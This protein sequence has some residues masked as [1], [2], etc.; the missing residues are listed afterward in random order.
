[1]PGNGIWLRL[2]PSAGNLGT[3]AA[4]PV[5]LADG[6]FPTSCSGRLL[7]A[8]WL[9]AGSGTS[10][11]AQAVV[12]PD[13]SEEDHQRLL[14][15]F[16]SVQIPDFDHAILGSF[17]NGDVK[18]STSAAVLAM[19]GTGAPE[20]VLAAH[21]DDFTPG[22]VLELG[23]PQGLSLAGGGSLGGVKIDA[24][25]QIVVDSAILAGQTV[26]VGAV[27][28]DAARVEVRVDGGQTVDA[29]LVTLPPS[30]LATFQS[31]TTEL[32]GIPS[33]T[34]VV[35]DAAGAVLTQERFYPGRY[36]SPRYPGFQVQP[37]G[38]IVDA[39]IY[40]GIWRL[41]DTGASIEL[42]DGT[43]TIA[44]VPDDPSSPLAF[45]THT[46][47]GDSDSQTIVFGTVSPDI[48]YLITTGHGGSNS[49]ILVPLPDGRLAFWM[50]T[51]TEDRLVALNAECGVVES[52]DLRSGAPTN[53]SPP[54]ECVP[55]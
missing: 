9:D 18:D 26:L 49:G 7:T 31:F 25:D 28:P 15:A 50:W 38:T 51:I 12:G 35:Y 48:T 16:S 54:P 2:D 19:S 27:S 30:L 6:A 37:D 23:R 41:T 32:A 5:E 1:M 29:E 11:Q 17:F 52:I 53:E 10:F 3:G 24:P 46:F 36:T 34:I 4:W 47:T 8:S 39:K 40:G 14:E 43:S 20:W 42:S 44:S 13:A 33:G 22:L 55:A 21:P 45:G